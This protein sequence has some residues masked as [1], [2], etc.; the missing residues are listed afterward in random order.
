M[1]KTVRMNRSAPEVK[2]HCFELWVD[3]R[4]IGTYRDEDRGKFSS[5]E[6]KKNIE[7]RDVWLL[8]GWLEVGTRKI[9]RKDKSSPLFDG[10]E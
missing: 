6:C 10:E 1:E 2:T 7:F 8:G 3:E 4:K 5:L 9:T